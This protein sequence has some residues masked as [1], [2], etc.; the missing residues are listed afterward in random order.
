MIHPPD[1][2]TLRTALAQ[3]PLLGLCVT[4][5]A[6]GIIERIG[7]DWDWIWIDGQHGEL[8]GSDLLEAVR[9]CDV[10][11][12]PA[13]VRVPGSAYGAIGKALDTAAAGVMA[14]MVQ[15]ATQAGE[16]VQAAKF[17]PLGIRSYGGRRPID[18]FGRSYAQPEHARQPL[19][20]CQ[21]ESPNGLKNVEAI[22]AVDGVDVLF[23]GADDMALQ[24]GLP[25]DQPRPAGYFDEALQRVAAAAAAEGKLAG[26]VFTTTEALQQAVE[27]GYRLIAGSADASLLAAGSREASQLLRNQIVKT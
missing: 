24:A 12:R 16:L 7:A 21:I 4:Y 20:I 27:L 10:V 14:P 8:H 18:R 15:D 17:P 5:P 3:Q 19:L 9:T 26:G 6:P 22:A 23:F 13:V 25:L 2:P 1:N 11:G